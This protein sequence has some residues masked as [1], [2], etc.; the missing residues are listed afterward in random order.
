MLN[1]HTS[2]STQYTVRPDR[3]SSKVLDGVHSKASRASSA[4]LSENNP[5]RQFLISIGWLRLFHAIVDEDYAR[6]ARRTPA[7]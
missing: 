6:S 4:T 2:M 1:R 7:V 5:A 3:R